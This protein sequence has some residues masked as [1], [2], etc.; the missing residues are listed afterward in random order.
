VFLLLR[1]G[2]G[3]PGGTRQLLR[4]VEYKPRFDQP[5]SS[6]TPMPPLHAKGSGDANFKLG[7]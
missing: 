5:I 6:I 3:V 1:G 4:L 7:L 2:I